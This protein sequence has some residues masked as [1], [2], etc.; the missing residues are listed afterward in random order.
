MLRRFTTIAFCLLFSFSIFL[1]IA[2]TTSAAPNPADM[3]AAFQKFDDVQKS[4]NSNGQKSL[5]DYAKE[6]CDRRKGNHM[7]L[8]TWYSGKCQ[9]DSLSGEGVGFSDI[10]ILD[11]VERFTGA[12]DKSSVDVLKDL[13][14]KMSSMPTG[15]ASTVIKEQNKIFTQFNGGL[16]G[17][18]ATAV[19]YP[20]LNKPASSLDYFAYVGNNLSKNH[21]IPPVFAATEGFGFSQLLPLLSIWRG[22]RNLA[23]TLFILVFI[24][25]GFMM[26]FRVN[27]GSKTV[28]TMQLAIPKLIF[29]LIIIT[30]SYAIVGL[31]IDLTE[32]ISLLPISIFRAAGLTTD[33]GNAFIWAARGQAGP[34]G[35]F[36]V[37]AFAA[38]VAGPFIIVNTLFG[39]VG[40]WLPILVGIF[41]AVSGIGLIIGLIIIIAVGI[42]YIK[43]I[44]KLYSAFFT[45]CVQ[46]IF[47]P[48]ILLGNVLPGSTAFSTWL[49]SLIA[50]LSVFPV[51][52]FFLM[53]SY[54]L[55]IQPLCSLMGNELSTYIFGVKDMSAAVGLGG[56]N[57]W[58]WNP[59]FLFVFN[60]SGDAVLA[61]IGF[62]LLLMAS[63]YVDIVREA[64]KVPPFKYGSAIGD[65]LKTG[66]KT[67][68]YLPSVGTNRV[69]TTAANV[70]G[71]PAGTPMGRPTPPSSTTP[72]STP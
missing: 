43:L 60:P 56:L 61:T 13:I 55:M 47:A 32:I 44:F 21:I 15:D 9:A 41:G 14:Q 70:F 5:N 69:Y 42:S 6:F 40:A 31:L 11:L 22:F 50:N 46:L 63:K 4:F 57:N 34:V 12:Q 72:V 68:G 48:I 8:E 65:A 25:Y 2:K 23:Y 52:I 35:S 49:M 24:V 66:F 71:L 67:S 29:T 28:I 30:F 58:M 37:N 26:M 39:S 1:S 7:N 16:L 3:V 19:N 18:L 36:V 33:V 62:G 54:I 17:S 64:L 51:A 45:I 20:L 59:P 10:I 27:L 53:L 38:L